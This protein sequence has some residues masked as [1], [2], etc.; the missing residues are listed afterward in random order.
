MLAFTS[1]ILLED[2]I[3]IDYEKLFT[4]LNIG[5]RKTNNCRKSRLGLPDTLKSTK[6]L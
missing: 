2:T 4:K 3:E 5:R 1:H 6:S